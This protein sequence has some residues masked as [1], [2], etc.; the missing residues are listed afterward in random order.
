MCVHICRH[1]FC[2]FGFFEPSQPEQTF[3]YC[4]KQSY[5]VYNVQYNDT[6]LLSNKLVT[7][8]D[9]TNALTFC[10]YKFDVDN[11]YFDATVFRKRKRKNAISAPIF[12]FYLF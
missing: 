8:M 10:L 1:C 2:F 12:Y 6:E 4:C 11:T 5:F 3:S 9:M 7:V